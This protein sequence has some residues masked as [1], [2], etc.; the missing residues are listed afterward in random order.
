M[1]AFLQALS[2]I[3]VGIGIFLIIGIAT[4]M[5]ILWEKWI[6]TYDDDKDDE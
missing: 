5:V 2:G 4:L 6:H 1:E 3:V